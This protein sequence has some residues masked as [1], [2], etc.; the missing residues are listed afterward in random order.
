MQLY[1]FIY[2]IVL[3]SLR[4]L[5]KVILEINRIGFKRQYFLCILTYLHGKFKFD[6]LEALTFFSKV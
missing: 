3:I 4:L 1:L 2:P 5:I 6:E